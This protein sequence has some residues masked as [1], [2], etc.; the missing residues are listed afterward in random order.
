MSLV[1]VEKVRPHISVVRMN[2]PERLNAMSFG[3]MT[4]LVDAFAEVAADN[5]CH[6][7]IL[8]GEGRGFCSGL[9]LEDPGAIPGIEHLPISRIGVVAMTHF[10]QIVPV[11]RAVPQPII[12]AINGCAY[13]GGLCLSLGADI[14]IAEESVVFNSTGIVNGLTSTELGASYLLPRLIG[15][16]R[17]NEILLTG[18]KVDALE[19]ERIGLVSRLVAD[20]DAVTTAI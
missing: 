1:I 9:D 16:S 4:A 3:L 13:G 2:R 18:R 12:A 8:T 20:G 14:R 19:A 10:S 5:T 15:A 11:M 6:V 17:S 7:V